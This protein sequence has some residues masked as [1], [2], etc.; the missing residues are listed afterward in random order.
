MSV[1]LPAGRM[2]ETALS[3][4]LVTSSSARTSVGA[5]LTGLIVKRN[6]SLTLNVPSLAIT[7]ISAK[8][9]KFAGGV[10][11]KRP[12]AT[13]KLSQDGK[14]LPLLS[15][16]L[17]VKASPSTSAKLPTGINTSTKLSSARTTSGNIS[18]STGASLTAVTVKRN[19]SLVFRL[20]SLAMT[21]IS[22]K[23]L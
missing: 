5:S 20:P 15:L 4:V 17:S 21:L 7:S 14:G 22:I 8:P 23:P 18:A 10:P 11:T 1:K 13:S 19:M 9:L 12:V 6:I 16:A 3:S 2:I